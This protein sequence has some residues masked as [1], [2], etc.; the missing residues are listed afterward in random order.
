MK[1]ASAPLAV[2]FVLTNVGVVWLA[3]LA[4]APGS[5]ELLFRV[6]KGGK[7]TK[8]FELS[9][10]CEKRAVSCKLRDLELPQEWLDRMEMSLSMHESRVVE[11]EYIETAGTQ[12][13]VL[14]RSFRT[15]T[16]HTKSHRMVIG[17]EPVIGKEPKDE[18]DD[19]ESPLV[20]HTVAFTWNE[21]ERKYE[22]AYRGKSGEAIWLPGLV[23]DTD[24]PTLLPDHK[25]AIGDTWKIDPEH[26]RKVLAPGGSLAFEKL[27]DVEFDKQLGGEATAK[28][29]GTRAVGG[30]K[31]GVIALNVRLSMHD[32]CDVGGEHPMKRE[33]SL[34]LD[35]E[36]LW[37]LEDEH[38]ASY[39]L[40]GPLVIT[41]TGETANVGRDGRKLE[42]K[43][44]FELAGELSASGRS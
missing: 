3:S 13:K 17:A 19:L 24:L 14:L 11:D 16:R 41:L 18:K 4:S 29:E 23:E 10:E 12:P 9:F 22:H 15:A 27:G 25:V 36:L 38:F 44:R 1:L 33:I 37:D 43:V 42:S 28:Y 31:L 35:G 7:V 30:R 20:D 32:D 34:V 26:F 39:E 5:E 21:N 8:H 2:R 6:P 40:R